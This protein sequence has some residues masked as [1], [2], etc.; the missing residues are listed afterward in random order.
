MLPFALLLASVGQTG[1]PKDAEIAYRDLWGRVA[2]I[3]TIQLTETVGHPN[4]PVIDTV[5]YELQRPN[6]SRSV[7]FILK[8][9]ATLTS[10]GDGKTEW[11]VGPEGYIK[12]P[13]V[14]DAMREGPT[15]FEQFS[16]PREMIYEFLDTAQANF[17]GEAATLIDLKYKGDSP[18][19]IGVYVSS[20]TR[21]PIGFRLT[22]T[23]NK[24][25][26]IGRYTNL[27]VNQPIDPSEFV[28]RLPSDAKPY[29]PDTS[30]SL[31][32]IG[33][34]A[35]KFSFSSTRGAKITL[36]SALKGKR[37]LL[38]NFWSCGCPPCQQELP[39]LQAKYDLLRHQGLGVIT[40]NTQDTSAEIAA[41]QKARKL[42]LP[43][44]ADERAKDRLTKVFGVKACPTNYVIGPNGKI[45]GAFVGYDKVGIAK[46]L[47]S[48]GLR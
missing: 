30:S 8:E 23:Q 5:R 29:M 25:V 22:S 27:V 14:P 40:V 37:A 38:I 24:R 16:N 47:N 10:V 18:M 12:H 46:A 36:A 13:A 20:Q 48:L 6:L 9:K 41:F 15:G 4:G 2:I 31:L 19:R 45:V 3:R 21:L 26:L 44:I 43:V 11:F 1:G 7:E 42:H 34:S 39:E 28:M 35:P 33:S 32:K 17:F